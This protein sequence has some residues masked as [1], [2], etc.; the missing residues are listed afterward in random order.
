MHL[1]LWS[2]NLNKEHLESLGLDEEWCWDA[3]YRNSVEDAVK[4]YVN[5]DRDQYWVHAYTAVHHEVV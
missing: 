4:I 2:Q 3:R 5:Q 1:V